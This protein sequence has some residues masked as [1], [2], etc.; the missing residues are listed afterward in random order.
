MSVSKDALELELLEAE[1]R[2]FTAEAEVAE[3]NSVLKA[4]EVEQTLAQAGEHGEVLFMAEVTDT[5]IYTL[6]KQ[7]ENLSN[8]FP[9][10]AIK[11][12]ID[13]PGGGILDGL[14]LY[15]FLQALRAKGHHITTHSRGMA[16]SMGGVLL[17]AGDW[18]TMSPNAFLLIHEASAG[19]AGSLPQM[20]DST[21]FV[22]RLQAKTT[23]IL[24]QCS[25]M[26]V[27]DIEKRMDRRDWW[28]DAD[29]ALKLGFIDQIVD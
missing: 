2:K 3:C 19:T 20:K 8:R 16:A 10:R 1:I 25:T 22:E 12:I 11:L 28:M 5:T 27:E 9:E 6:M 23:E 17:Q 13:S 4:R 21:A 18:R 14:H 29:E 26:S 7:L 15:D 24:A